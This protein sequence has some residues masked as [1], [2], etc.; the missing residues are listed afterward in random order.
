M[1]SVKCSAD[2]TCGSTINPKPVRAKF[3]TKVVGFFEN[4]R[5][6]LTVIP[7][8]FFRV[9]LGQHSWEF[10]RPITQRN[11]F[12][13]VSNRPQSG[14]T[15]WYEMTGPLAAKRGPIEGRMERAKVR[16]FLIEVAILRICKPFFSLVFSPSNGVMVRGIPSGDHGTG[17][18]IAILPMTCKGYAFR[19]RYKYHEKSPKFVSGNSWF[20]FISRNLFLQKVLNISNISSFIKY[21]LQ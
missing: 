18:G 17:D 20:F 21:I 13:F 12:V 8:K 11:N 7:G 16:Y 5:E 4:S 3:L 1:D 2:F 14:F 9:N 10:S 15:G 6:S 19:L